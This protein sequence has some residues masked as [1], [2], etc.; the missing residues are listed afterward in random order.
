MIGMDFLSFLILLVISVIVSL[1][2]HYVLK[3]YV[4]PGVWS[5]CG[6]VAI[7]WVGAWLGSPVLGYWFAGV[8]YNEV[9]FIPAI[10]G[11]LAAVILAVDVVKSAKGATAGGGTK[12]G[13]PTM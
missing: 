5:F 6:K 9:Y 11:S 13:A 4:V 3:F 2:L 8:N 10:I 12:P 7:G 1:I